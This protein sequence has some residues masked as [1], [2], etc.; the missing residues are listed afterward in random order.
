MPAANV[1]PNARERNPIRPDAC[2]DCGVPNR[3]HYGVAGSWLGCEIA[4]VSRRVSDMPKDPERW[5]DA[6]L[7]TTL[8]LR[9]ALVDGTLG[10]RME[11]ATGGMTNDEQLALAHAIAAIVRSS[12]LE[13]LAKKVG[14][15]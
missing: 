3:L 7:Q 13:A 14:A 9:A 12:D 10:P 15:L 4:K 11:I 5:N 6:F 2:P 1:T 8:R